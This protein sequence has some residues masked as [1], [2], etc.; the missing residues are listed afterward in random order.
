MCRAECGDENLVSLSLFPGLLRSV[1]ASHFCALSR[2]S[3]F[4]ALVLQGVVIR[5]RDGGMQSVLLVVSTRLNAPGLPLYV[6][7]GVWSRQTRDELPRRVL[8]RPREIYKLLYLR[9]DFTVNP[10]E[11][12]I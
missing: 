10:E 3:S 7:P 4:S 9:P 8:R 11:K 6:L 1:P 12:Q 2:D 5:T